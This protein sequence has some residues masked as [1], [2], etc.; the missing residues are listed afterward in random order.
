MKFGSFIRGSIFAKIFLRVLVLEFVIINTMILNNVYHLNKALDTNLKNW[1]SGT[2]AMLSY[3]LALFVFEED[4][5]GALNYANNLL[6]S[7]SDMHALRVYDDRGAKFIEIPQ[8]NEP[9][10]NDEHFSFPLYI[11]GEVVGKAE[12]VIY[13]NI[14]N[15][16]I[17]EQIQKSYLL[18]AVLFLLNITMIGLVLKGFNKKIEELLSII[19]KY[20][21]ENAPIPPP[22][23]K[24]SDEIGRIQN[25]LS[26][27]SKA[28]EDKRL[29]LEDEIKNRDK[30]IEEEV[31]KRQKQEAILMQ[32]ARFAQMAEMLTMISHHWR[33]PLSVIGL[34]VQNLQDAYAF[35]EL[36]EKSLNEAVELV[37]KFLEGLSSTLYTLATLSSR[38]K[39]ERVFN[40]A[41]STKKICELARAEMET[42]F[43]ELKEEIDEGISIKGVPALYTQI[44]M[45]LLKNA[46]EAVMSRDVN[47]RKVTVS[48]RQSGG[49]IVLT[50]QD[51]GGGVD[52]KL[53][54]R[55]FDPF[56]TTKDITSKTGLGLYMVKMLAEE[57]FD[58]SI[59]VENKNS[60]AGFSVI[61]PDPTTNQKEFYE[62]D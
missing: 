30:T 31:E 18:L 52:E 16:S 10:G 35:G 7:K 3:P 51:S 22:D 62:L 34:T 8:K 33:Q 1:I 57:Q 26:S 24:E 5:S 49:G 29:L 50:M 53:L 46:E 44:V 47:H 15:S 39:E 23:S 4:V 61:F 60:G 59:E 14:I 11:G 36:T 54:P 40:A 12:V 38:Q 28:L 55:L 25:A 21:K 13:A 42:M 20:K 2:E 41:D 19:E 9:E 6:G 56:F 32:Q 17:K 37:M 45:H 58:A 27:L 48:L 43:I